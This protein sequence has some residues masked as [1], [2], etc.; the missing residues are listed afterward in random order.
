MKSLNVCHR[1]A[2]EQRERRAEVRR[3]IV[4]TLQGVGV[5]VFVLLILGIED[6]IEYVV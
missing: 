2:S 4:G 6:W 5:C 1:A 3:E